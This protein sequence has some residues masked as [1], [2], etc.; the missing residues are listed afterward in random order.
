MLISRGQYLTSATQNVLDDPKDNWD[1][2]TKSSPLG[3]SHRHLLPGY[4]IGPLPRL[5]H[6]YGL[7][8]KNDG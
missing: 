6:S 8:K 7:N 4:R 1:N 2:C 5:F 3:L